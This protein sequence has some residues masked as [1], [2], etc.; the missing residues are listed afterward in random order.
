MK[1]LKKGDDIIVIAG[2]DKGKRGTIAS[3]IGNDKVLVQGVYVIKKHQKP[4]PSTGVS[5]GIIEI[6]KP[7]DKS[8]V[9]I[10]NFTTKK[11]DR[12]GFKKDDNNKQKRIF[13]SSGELV[14]N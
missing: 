14:G 12:I 9:A 11:G 6:A 7:I 1:K 2:K 10:F 4:N 13:K 5:G 3:I 8:N